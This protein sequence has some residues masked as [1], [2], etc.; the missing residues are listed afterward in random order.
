MNDCS[1]E[2]SAP[3]TYKLA[4]ITDGDEDLECVLHAKSP[5]AV[6]LN[7]KLDCCHLYQAFTTI[8]SSLVNLAH[9]KQWIFPNRLQVILRHECRFTRHFIDLRVV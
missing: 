2:V 6:R 7:G 3:H 4:T 5:S 1:V 8:Y 9:K